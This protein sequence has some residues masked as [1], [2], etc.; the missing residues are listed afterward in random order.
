MAPLPPQH[1]PLGFVDDEGHFF[2]HAS[3]PKS[4]ASY[5]QLTVR[6]G[7]EDSLTS[8]YGLILRPVSL[9]PNSG[10]NVSELKLG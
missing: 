9:R 2:Y 6:L 1:H 10:R 8:S 3:L 5:F 7:F 4:A